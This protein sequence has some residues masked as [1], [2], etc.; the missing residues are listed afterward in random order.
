MCRPHAGRSL[1]AAR[2][3]GCE[4]FPARVRPKLLVPTGLSEEA[5]SWDTLPTLA[6]QRKPLPASWAARPTLR[7]REHQ[8]RP[9]PEAPSQPRS[10]G[11][12]CGQKQ[13]SETSAIHAKGMTGTATPSGDR[14]LA[15]RQGA[16]QGQCLGVGR[17]ARASRS[18]EALGAERREARLLPAMPA[19][20]SSAL[21]CKNKWK[22]HTP[23]RKDGGKNPTPPHMGSLG[24]S[25]PRPWPGLLAA[26]FP[27]E[28][29]GARFAFTTN[30]DNTM[31]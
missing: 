23:D 11:S 15:G 6:W 30:R 24:G 10:R 26:A 31:S 17:A 5:R 27:G 3:L 12:S 4:C 18:E 22:Q 13:P 14:D 28:A 25:G 16:K 20:L 8:P 2:A 29:A 19:C 1:V 7:R 9:V 21:H